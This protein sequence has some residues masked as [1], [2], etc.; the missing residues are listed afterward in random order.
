[1]TKCLTYLRN[2]AFVLGLAVPMGVRAEP[3]DFIF[4]YCDEKGRNFSRGR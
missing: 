1:M 4:Y 3:L 2:V